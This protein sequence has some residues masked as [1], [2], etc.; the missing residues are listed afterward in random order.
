MKR[1]KFQALVTLH[2]LDGGELGAE[3]GPS[4]CRMV[5]R[6]ENIQTRRHQL[7]STLVSSYGEGPF[8]QG[9][10]QVIVTLQLA[11]DDVCDYLAVGEHFQ[12]W[13]QGDVADGVIS[14]R[15][16]V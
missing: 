1:Y 11:G 14:R 8:G 3:L 13:R 10:P 7:F 5:L 4:P 6:A 15:L 16:F 2:P 12:L 9:D